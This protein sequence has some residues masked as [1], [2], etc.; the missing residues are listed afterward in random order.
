MLLSVIRQHNYLNQSKLDLFVMGIAYFELVAEFEFVN[1]YCFDT[2]LNQLDIN[3]S[4][5][6]LL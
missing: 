2:D 6:Y 4:S 1:L 3:N 5:I